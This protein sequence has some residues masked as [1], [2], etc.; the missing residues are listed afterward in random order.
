MADTGV[1]YLVRS[2]GE[3]VKGPTAGVEAALESGYRLATPEQ[4]AKF[5]A[6]VQEAQTYGT[7]GQAILTG[8][9]KVAKGAT[10]GLSTYLETALG[11]D[12]EAIKARERQNPTAAM[13]GEA[14][15]IAAPL[16]LTGGV[17]AGAAGAAGAARAGA[18]GAAAE[19]GLLSRA[20]SLTAP[21]LAARAGAGVTAA[22]RAALPEATSLAGQI[23][24]QAAAAGA[25]SAVEGAFYG[26]GNVVHESAL[27]DPHLTA[28]SALA[29]VGLNAALFGG[30][31]GVFGAA[32]V[33]LPAA[34]EKVR[35]TLR[36]AFKTAESAYA[37][38]TPV[39]GVAKDVAE[40]MLENK[41][42]LSALEAVS[43][44]TLKEVSS[45][46]PE[47]AKWVASN[48]TKLAELEQ[49]FPGTTKR[50]ARVEPKTADYL[51]ENWPKIITDPQARIQA[52]TTLSDDM[53][54]VIEA[55]SEALSRANA[56]ISPAEA[57]ALLA[58][59]DA[60]AV[61]GARSMIMERMQ[62][63]VDAMRAKPELYD[64]AYAKHLEGVLEGLGRDLSD[65][66]S[67]LAT[68][69]RLKKLRQS[70]D[71][72]IPYNAVSL[73]LSERQAVAEMKGLRSLV[74]QVLVDEGVFG[75]QAARQAALD[76]VQAEWLGLM[77]RGGDFNSRFMVKRTGT[78]GA[79]YELKPT[80]INTWLNQ[81]IDARGQDFSEAWAKAIGSARKVADVV[82]ASAVNAGVKDFDRAALQSLLDKASASTKGIEERA[83][84]TQV[85]NQLDP[86]MSWG[87]MPFVSREAVG[88]AQT[89]AG[90]VPG[91]VG[92][93]L[94]G[95]LSLTREAASVPRAVSVLAALERMSQAVSRK[96]DSAMTKVVNSGASR[97]GN[98]A[99]TTTTALAASPRGS[100][101]KE[102]TRYAEMASDPSVM[103][104]ALDEQAQQTNDAAPDTTVAL[105]AASTR[106]VSFLASKAPKAPK[107]GPLAPEW[108]PSAAE[109]ATF[110]RYY[111]A[112]QSP[113][114]VLKQA[115]EGTLTP[116]AVE[117]VATV[118]PQ[119][120]DRIR[121]AAL[122]KLSDRTKPVPYR[123]RL[124]LSLLLGQDMD[125]SLSASAAVAAA[126]AAASGPAAT[127]KPTPAA[128]KVTLPQRFLTQ[129][130]RVSAR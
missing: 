113:L 95:T 85:M 22:A 105:G 129:Q 59:A 71:E 86:R 28:Q 45:A 81:M 19:A 47:M 14:V 30:L 90:Y 78:G 93:T 66:S 109:L 5:E 38:A 61:S 54:K 94:R 32:G 53:A 127:P 99:A 121:F 64:Q 15:G 128:G 7:T 41:L 52:A 44:G 69:T 62:G 56:E 27:G 91:I 96:I 6:D 29:E 88:A 13:I 126:A 75:A 67:P 39:T 104:T 112:V 43:P 124:M 82:D 23:A 10:G 24:R 97:V 130:Q 118:Y 63:A 11:V 111:E 40:V 77:K 21:A 57:R 16:L 34:A 17:S 70:M 68:F 72:V 9:E 50:L 58:N 92:S 3:I 12:P 116:E 48:H 119:L 37:S 73:G 114:S 83:A 120:M 33:A 122:D 115:Q 1:S 89:A 20:A 103:M 74:K 49:A 107:A 2:D 125:G 123:Q 65:A 55:T 106:A 46:T 26:L 42:E 25:G 117:A 110:R 108:E 80:K 76:E 60:E 4:Q 79:R 101:A 84:V 51:L 98:V 100:L 8:A 87:S 18:A 35:D 31:G 36:G 102:A